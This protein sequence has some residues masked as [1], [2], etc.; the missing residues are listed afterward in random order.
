MSC[1]S[2]GTLDVLVDILECMIQGPH[3]NIRWQYFTVQNLIDLLHHKNQQINALKLDQ[4]NLE[5]SLLIWDQ[6]LEAFK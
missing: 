6:H 1:V 5:W 2:L 3:E 4:L